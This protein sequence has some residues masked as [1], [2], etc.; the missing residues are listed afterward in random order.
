MSALWPANLKFNRPNADKRDYYYYDAIQITV[1]TSGA[2]TFTSKSYFGAVGYLYESS[3]D[4][5]NPSN[6]LIHFGDVVGINGEFEIDV[7]L[8]N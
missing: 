3:F 5:S 1:Y 4:P 8:S 2:Y 7:S 6:N